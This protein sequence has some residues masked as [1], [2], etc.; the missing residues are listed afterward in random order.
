MLATPRKARKHLARAHKI[1][2]DVAVA[3]E[4]FTD[5][6]QEYDTALGILQWHRCP[7]IEWTV[8]L[9]AA[10]TASAV[11]DTSLADRYLG[12]CRQ[13]IRQLADS[14]DEDKLR[15]NFLASEAIRRILI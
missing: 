1:L 14:L 8:L 5:A 12:R 3:E 9:A 4:R 11:R 2:G 15:R 10:E 6:R 13:V 7:T